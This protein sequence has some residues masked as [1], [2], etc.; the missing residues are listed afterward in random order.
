MIGTPGVRMKLKDQCKTGAR[1]LIMG[2]YRFCE[3][4]RVDMENLKGN[5]ATGTIFSTLDLI[6]VLF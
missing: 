4:V 6:T 3:A 5:S 1:M 2:L